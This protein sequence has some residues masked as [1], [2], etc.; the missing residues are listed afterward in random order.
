MRKRFKINRLCS[1]DNYELSKK[2]YIKELKSNHNST[3][4][5]EI[6]MNCKKIAYVKCFDKYIQ[7][8]EEDVIRLQS[9]TTIIYR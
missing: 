3:I 5:T 7:I 9:T 8:S 4:T 1:S 6:V 2:L